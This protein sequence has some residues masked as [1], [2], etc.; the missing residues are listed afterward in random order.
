[1]QLTLGADTVEVAVGVDAGATGRAGEG[2]QALVNVVAR[3][4]VGGQREARAAA[5]VVRPVRVHALV[6]TP[7]VVGVA[8]VHVCGQEEQKMKKAV[9]SS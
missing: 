7:A 3:H 1:M 6:L 8:L 5:A 2:V 9:T 4:G